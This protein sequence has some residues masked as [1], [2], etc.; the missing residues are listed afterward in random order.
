[1]FFALTG[2]FAAA[3]REKWDAFPLLW[4]CFP[5]LWHALPLSV[6]VAAWRGERPV[7]MI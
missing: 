7:L 4:H 1:M 6:R 5:L 3:V 2:R